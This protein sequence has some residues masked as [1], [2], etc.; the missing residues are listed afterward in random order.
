MKKLIAWISVFTI[1]CAFF[2]DF[3][4]AQ[5]ETPIKFRGIEW[6][7]QFADVNEQ[8]GLS[9]GYSKEYI[10]INNDLA[11]MDDIDGDW[12]RDEN[13]NTITGMGIEVWYNSVDVAGYSAIPTL[14]CIYPIADGATI[15]NENEAELYKAEYI[16]D[17]YTDAVSVYMDLKEK[18]TSVYGNGEPRN[19]SFRKECTYWQDEV[20]NELLLSRAVGTV[21]ISYAANGHRERLK[22]LKEVRLAEICKAEAEERAQNTENTSGL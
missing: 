17:G 18:L 11:V 19:V 7:T 3:A 2:V 22:A 14:Y 13:Y 10:M 16:I 8:L 21:A 1:L 6:Y 12:V 9:K 20:G 5:S 15:V 4:C